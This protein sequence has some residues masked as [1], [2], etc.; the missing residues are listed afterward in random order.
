MSHYPLGGWVRPPR[1]SRDWQY[2][3]PRTLL[4]AG[5]SVEAFDL[6]PNWRGQMFDQGSANT[7]GPC[8]ASADILHDEYIQNTDPAPTP[9]RQF[10][11]WIARQFQGTLDYPSGV[12]N[13]SMLKALAEHGWCKNSLCPDDPDHRK[14]P[15]DAAFA[16]AAARKNTLTYYEVPRD[17]DQMRACL[18]GGDPFLIG[19]MAYT[20]FRSTEVLSTGVMPMPK[21]GEAVIGGHAVVACGFN[22]STGRIK[23]KNSYGLGWGS[24]GFGEIPYAYLLDPN[25]SGD[26]RTIRWRS[27]APAPTPVPTPTPAVTDEIRV[28]VVDGKLVVIR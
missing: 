4:A 22:N 17:L 20:S 26:F 15:S 9:S 27:T 7:C 28:Q 5:A 25:L 13:Y 18:V 10:I 24:K 21:A 16:D 3:A 23:F 1:D 2:A 8:A 11:W 14:R 6:G 19:F 12:S